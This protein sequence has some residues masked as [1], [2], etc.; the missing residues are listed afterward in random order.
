[1]FGFLRYL[2][3]SV[4]QD[5]RPAVVT[6]GR[7][8]PITTGHDTLIKHVK[9]TADK[10]GSNGKP[11]YHEVILSHS[12][13]PKKNP[14]NIQQKLDYARK[15]Y[16]DTNFVGSTKEHPT[17]LHH[18]SRLYDRGHRDVHLVVGGDRV[19]EFSE[20]VKK[21]NGV[22]GRHGHFNF[23]NFNVHSAGDRDPD[24]EGL[25]GMSA[26]KM[27]LAAG[28][29]DF[30]NFRKGIPEHVPDFEAKRLYNDVRKGMNI[31]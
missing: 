12:Q 8:N 7:M 22:P 13:D 10:F 27:R 6:F 9:N 11:A 30:D 24:A 25:E 14:L 1:M 23:D 18:L 3:E 5:T 17:L 26:S 31:E 21:Y 15:F 16:P 4:A 19:P 2:R 29:G 20:L 28:A